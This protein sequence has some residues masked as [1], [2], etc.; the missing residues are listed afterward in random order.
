VVLEGEGVAGTSRCLKGWL[1]HTVL[2]QSRKLHDYF[3]RGD[4]EVMHALRSLRQR[5]LSG[6]GNEVA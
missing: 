1:L 2:P 5:A 3:G 6:S 4:N